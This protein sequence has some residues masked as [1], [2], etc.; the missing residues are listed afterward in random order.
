VNLDVKPF[1]LLY[2]LAPAASLVV[3][4]VWMWLVDGFGWKTSLI[5]T[6][7]AKCKSLW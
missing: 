4:S 1:D 2:R 7:P 5:L 3:S 6:T